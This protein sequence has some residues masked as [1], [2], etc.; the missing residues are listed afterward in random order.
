MDIFTRIGF[1]VRLC[2]P[3]AFLCSICQVYKHFTVL[4]YGFGQLG[5]LICRRTIRIKIR[6]SVKNR[7]M[8]DIRIDGIAKAH[9]FNSRFFVN[10]WQRPW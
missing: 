1:K 2:H 10:H 4:Y 3:D 5:N 9:R 7:G 6:F 8:V